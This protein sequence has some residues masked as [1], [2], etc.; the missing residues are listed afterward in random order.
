MFVFIT[1]VKND[2]AD[3]GWG[4][5][6]NFCKK[7]NVKVRVQLHVAVINEEMRSAES[8]IPFKSLLKTHVYRST[9]PDI[10]S[11]VISFNCL[12][13]PLKMTNLTHSIVLFMFFLKPDD[14]MTCLCE[15]LCNID[16]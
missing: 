10:L 11:V 4:V 14:F 9:F 3:F 1:Q 7:S 8:V 6:V 5:V 16:F 2:D 13:F 15:A 12:L